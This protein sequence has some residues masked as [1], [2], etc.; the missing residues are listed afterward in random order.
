[1]ENQTLYWDEE[2]GL[3]ASEVEFDIAVTAGKASQGG[4]LKVNVFNIGGAQANIPQGG[5]QTAPSAAVQSASR[6]KFSVPIV[7]PSSK[8]VAKKAKK[9]PAKKG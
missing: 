6:V 7:M 8:P 9:R 1:M 2:T 3:F 4:G 5:G